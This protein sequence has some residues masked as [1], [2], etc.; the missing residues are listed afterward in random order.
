MPQIAPLIK[1]LKKQ[2]KA[3]GKTYVDVAQLLGLSEASVKRMF[4]SQNF[5][6]HRLEEI[7]HFM[8]MELSDLVFKMSTEQRTN[9][10]SK[11]S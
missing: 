10:I 4:A 9:R 5:T 3:Q 6:L 7:C 2:L 1:T 11:R 8:D